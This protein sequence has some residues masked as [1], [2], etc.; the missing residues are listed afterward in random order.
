MFASKY[1]SYDVVAE[2]DKIWVA[3]GCDVVSIL[4]IKDK[5]VQKIIVFKNK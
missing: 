3:I 2:N 5:E 1:I 4:S